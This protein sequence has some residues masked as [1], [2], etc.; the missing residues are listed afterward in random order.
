MVMVCSGLY[1]IALLLQLVVCVH[2]HFTIISVCMY[3]CMYVYY[4]RMY[5]YMPKKVYVPDSGLDQIH[6][7]TKQ[8]GS[9][10]KDGTEKR[11]SWLL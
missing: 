9:N 1:N 11:S 6:L 3:V 5:M 8:Y 10:T 7:N 4:V 2:A